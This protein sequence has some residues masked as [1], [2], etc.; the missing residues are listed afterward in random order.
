[1]R[2][3]TVYALGQPIDLAIAMQA[4]EWLTTLMS[5]VTTPA[6]RPAARNAFGQSAGFSGAVPVSVP[7]DGWLATWKVSVGLSGSVAVS[8]MG[9]DVS[10]GVLTD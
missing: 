2:A 7:C 10:S 6:E 4:A 3:A 5:G 9:L 1:M 8:T